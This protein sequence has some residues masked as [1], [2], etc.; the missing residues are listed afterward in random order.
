MIRLRLLFVPL[1]LVGCAATAPTT[2]TQDA[3]GHLGEVALRRGDAAWRADRPDEALR[4]Y[5]Q[6]VEADPSSDLPL[7]RISMLHETLGRLDLAIRASQ[8]AAQRNARN[9]LASQRL[10]YLWLRVGDAE[11]AAQEFTRALQL[12]ADLWAS[13]MGLGLAAEQRGDTTSARL[14][15]DEALALRP[16]SAELLAYSAR[17][18]LG[19]GDLKR[20]RTQAGASLVAGPSTTGRLVWGDVLA[21]SGEYPA[22]LE[23]YHTVLEA[24]AAYRRLADQA[25]IRRDYPAAVDFFE[26]ALRASPIHSESTMKRLA[27]AREHVAT[28]TRRSPR[29]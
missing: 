8:I 7:L 10:G 11:Q 15:Y 3:P 27:V 28:S 2:K 4:Q 6:A 16:S 20:A 18:D 23:T 19:L 5:L 12:D 13:C 29:P 21:Q 14:H 26:G 9:G 22:A 17:V 24:S 25:M 1:L